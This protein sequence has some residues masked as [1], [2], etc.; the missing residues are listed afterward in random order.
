[1]RIIAV[2][3]AKGGTGKTTT[4]LNV[5]AALSLCG[6]KVLLIDMDSQGHLSISTG[7]DD[8]KPS[9]ITI[10]EVLNGSGD[11][12]KAIRT[13]EGRTAYDIIPADMRLS[14]G[15]VEFVQREGYNYLLRD[16]LG[17]LRTSYDYI[18][19]DCA[20]GFNVLTLNAL[21][22]A[23]EVLIPVQANYLPLK[24]V[25]ALREAVEAVSERFNPSL[26]VGG[27]VVTFYDARGKLDNEIREALKE[28]FDGEVYET[29]LSRCKKLGEAPAS[30][31]DI[32]DYAFKSVGSTQY[33]ALAQ[34]IIKRGAKNG[35]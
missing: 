12:N 9:D 30:G 7:L 27:I 26:K 24:G 35:R 6:F 3:N 11:I 20:T 2:L 34:E 29:T 13:H 18:L 10:Y 33:Q 4:A 8:L 19:I 28:A 22:A 5:G 32:L 25:Q 1:M 16:A 31:K 15:E 14:A 17:K 23:T 21:A